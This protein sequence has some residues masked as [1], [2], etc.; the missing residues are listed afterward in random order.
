MTTIDTG[1]EEAPRTHTS[2]GMFQLAG[3]VG[4]LVSEAVRQVRDT[5]QGLVDIAFTRGSDDRRSPL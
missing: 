5:G 4:Y 3:C 2:D 1:F